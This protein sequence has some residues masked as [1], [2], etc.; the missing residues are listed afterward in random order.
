MI[1]YKK[2]DEKNIILEKKMDGDFS[3]EIINEIFNDL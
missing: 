3:D 1:L 2:K